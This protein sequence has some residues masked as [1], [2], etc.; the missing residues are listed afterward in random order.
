[1]AKKGDITPPRNPLEEQIAGIWKRI[2]GIDEIGVHQSFFDVG[3][4]SLQATRVLNRMKA[5]I[6]PEIGIK[7]V[8]QARTI[9]ELAQMAERK[10]AS[11][12]PA[13]GDEPEPEG[14]YYCSFELELAGEMT[15]MY[16][17]REE[18]DEEGLPHGAQNVRILG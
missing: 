6:S 2:L 7:D 8:V 4:D 14:E 13:A 9:A 5:E 1:M 15:K 18:F 17:S 3:G 11:A 10:L 12:S 16:M